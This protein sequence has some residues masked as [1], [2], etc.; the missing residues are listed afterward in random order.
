MARVSQRESMRTRK[1][2]PCRSVRFTRRWLCSRHRWG[3][4]GCLRYATLQPAM[5]SSHCGAPLALD[6]HAL[7][8]LRREREVERVAMREDFRACMPFLMPPCVRARILRLTS[9][10]YDKQHF[11][12]RNHSSPYSTASTGT[13]M[14]LKAALHQRYI[15]LLPA[16]LQVYVPLSPERVV[17]AAVPQI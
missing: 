15:C 17:C 11:L 8:E 12:K 7:F 5:V 1:N 6:E 16:V 9:S 3:D 4:A 13:G 14:T 2:T 10:T